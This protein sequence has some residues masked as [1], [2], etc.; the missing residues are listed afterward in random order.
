[1]HRR[2]SSPLC[3]STPVYA[4]RERKRK[5]NQEPGLVGDATPCCFLPSNNL[6]ASSCTRYQSLDKLYLTSSLARVPGPAEG[7]HDD[8]DHQQHP[9]HRHA[10]GQR[11]GHL[12]LG[13]ALH[14][15]PLSNP[16]FQFQTLRFLCIKR[17]SGLVWSAAT[18]SLLVLL[19]LLSP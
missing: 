19:L 18:K 11:L 8:G 13:S 15:K 12:G 2:D 17:K 1:M 6:T 9:Q 14:V 4:I 16:A 3:P 10:D 7:G 5:T